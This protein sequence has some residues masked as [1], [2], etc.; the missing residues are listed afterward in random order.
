MDLYGLRE[1]AVEG[2]VSVPDWWSTILLSVAAW[3]TFQLLANDDI[4]DRPRRWLLRLGKEWQKEGDPFPDNYRLGWAQFL[5]CPYC[6]GAHVALWWW[7]AWEIEAR[8]TEIIAAPF[9][10][11]AGVIAAA[12]IL[13][14]E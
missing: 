14:D 11:S 1:E 12:K 5:T 2:A 4:L 6:M 8:W 7:I 9:V 13:S 10:I 3:R